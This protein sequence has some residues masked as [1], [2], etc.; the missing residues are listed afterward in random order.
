MTRDKKEAK[1]IKEL[2]SKKERTVLTEEAAKARAQK[3]KAAEGTQKTV[4]KM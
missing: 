1:K 3:V 2:E 4:M